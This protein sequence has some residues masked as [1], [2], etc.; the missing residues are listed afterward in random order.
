MSRAASAALALLLLVIVPGPVAAVAAEPTP[1]TN[2]HAHNDYA[3]ARPLLDALDHGFCSIEADVWR[4]GDEL[5]VGHT[6][7]ELAPQRTLEALYLKPLADRIAAHDGWVYTRNLPVTLLIDIKTDGATTYALLRTQLA[8]YPQLFGRPAA[9]QP[10]QAPMIAVLSGDRPIS[11]VA[12]DADRVCTIDGRLPDL[13]TE[14]DAQL[15]PLVSDA[16]STE[17]H[18]TGNGPMPAAERD[19]LRRFVAT[20]HSQGR[21]LRFWATPD[22]EAVWA[23]LTAAGVDLIGADDLDRLQRFLSAPPKAA[24]RP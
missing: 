8:K 11:V 24:P 1:L 6:A 5:L 19:K 21:R 3:H 18:W 9:G 2:A 14:Q 22:D 4:V 23:E 10:S 20:A 16:W 15:V 12:A 13:K 17:F 7:L